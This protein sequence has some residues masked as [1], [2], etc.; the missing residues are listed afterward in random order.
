MARCRFRRCRHKTGVLSVGAFLGAVSIAGFLSLSAL[1][2]ALSAVVPVRAETYRSAGPRGER[3]DQPSLTQCPDLPLSFI[4]APYL[5]QHRESP[6]GF[7]DAITYK[8]EFFSWNKRLPELMKDLRAR[9]VKGGGLQAFIWKRVQGKNPDGTYTDFKWDEYDCLVRY[10][11]A[12]GI[13]LLAN[14]RA[15]EPEAGSPAGERKVP[16]L[17]RDIEQYKKFVSAVVERYD[18]D[19]IDDMPGLRYAVKY[20][21]IEEEPFMRAYWVGTAEDYATT[22]SVAYDAVKS[23]DPE[24]TVIA[25]ALY[26]DDLGATTDFAERFFKKLASISE[27]LKKYDMLDVHWFYKRIMA[28]EVQYRRIVILRDD[29]WKIERK[30]FEEASPFIVTETTGIYS[31]EAE[32]AQ[33]VFKRYI[34]ALSVGAKKVFWTALAAS[35]SASDPFSK[36]AIVARD[37]TGRLVKRPAYHTFRLMASKFDGADFEG[38]TSVENSSGL[39]VFKVLRAGRPVWIAWND[40]RGGAQYLIKDVPYK[41]VSVTDVVPANGSFNTEIMNVEGRTLR[42]NLTERPLIIEDETAGMISF[43][44]E[45]LYDEPAHDQDRPGGPQQRGEGRNGQSGRCGDGVCGPVERQKGVC[46]EDCRQK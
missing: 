9:W 23:A 2:I 46:P 40:N 7:L 44:A 24:A 35:V 45:D 20:W 11:Q 15:V 17:P 32:H 37:S 10:L 38:M 42:L 21:L 18:N 6:F 1:A 39:Y 26:F 12:N 4:P 31:G 30:Y 13:E 25:A 14:I 5:P 36:G 34:Y 19:G 16:R 43:G 3:P 33:D 28:S 8:G 41:R 27:G 22:L 29:V